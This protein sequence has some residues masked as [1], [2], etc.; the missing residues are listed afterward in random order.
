MYR[1]SIGVTTNM[2]PS[3]TSWIAANADRL[4][5]DSIWVGEDIELGQDVTVLSAALISHT[6]RPRIGTAII[7]ITVYPVQRIARMAATLHETGRGRFVLGIGIGGMQ[8]LKQLGIRIQKPVT[9]LRETM[10]VLRALWAGESVTTETELMSLKQ[11]EL[12]ISNPVHMKIFLG[13][14]G[15]QMLRL[16]G[17]LADGVV[18]SGPIDYLKHA[19]ELVDRAAVAAGRRPSDVEKV[20]W[21]PTIPTFKGGKEDLAK[22]VVSIVVADTPPAVLDLLN[23]DRDR[24]ERLKKAVAESGP[25]SGIPLVNQELLEMFSI[26]GSK[27]HMVDRFE[28]LNS[29]GLTEVVLGPPFSGKWREAVEEIFQEI[30]SRR[31]Q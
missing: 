2:K 14:R 20:A 30:Q 25:D 27:A 8:D 28:E 22:K 31:S 18:L 10:S 16:S 6:T 29:L 3:A 4:G 13:V 23:I 9:E 15:P 7:P 1:A 17:E 12:R 11:Y 26:T 5:L 19:V 21:L 24:V